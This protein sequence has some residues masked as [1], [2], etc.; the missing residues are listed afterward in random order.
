MFLLADVCIFI[1]FLVL[2]EL[3][4]MPGQQFFFCQMSVIDFNMKL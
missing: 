1:Y 2:E 3:F 4:N